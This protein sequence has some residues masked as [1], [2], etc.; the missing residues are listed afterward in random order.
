VSGVRCHVDSGRRRLDL[1]E[2]IGK[3]ILGAAIL[4]H[5][6]GGYALTYDRPS[7][8]H[9]PE[10]SS[11]MVAVRV[12]EAGRKNGSTSIHEGIA[13][14]RREFPDLDNSAVDNAH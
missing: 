3:G 11:G 5:D 4:T 8:P 14:A 13:C 1:G 12:D 6:D 9:F 2:E 10:Q 7:G